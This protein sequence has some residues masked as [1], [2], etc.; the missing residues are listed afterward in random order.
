MVRHC[1][2]WL[3]KARQ[4]ISFVVTVRI[5]KAWPAVASSGDAR[6]GEAR[7]GKVRQATNFEVME[8]LGSAC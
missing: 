7:S 3:G 5:G 6:C 1:A 8:R 4:A 2:D